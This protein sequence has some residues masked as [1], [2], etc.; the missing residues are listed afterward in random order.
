V[1]I[2]SEHLHSA[3]QFDRR[4]T[5]TVGRVEFV[6]LARR[7]DFQLMD[8]RRS[9]NSNH[10]SPYLRIRLEIFV[11]LNRLR[12][13]KYLRDLRMES[14]MLVQGTD[15]VGRIHTNAIQFPTG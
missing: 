11:G 6:T 1:S 5:L 14:G 7:H 13:R 15:N 10:N 3:V 8:A 2:D 12:K 4:Y 9:R